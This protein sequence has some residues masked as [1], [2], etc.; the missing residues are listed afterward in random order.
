MSR[1]Y[2]NSPR[3]K[4]SRRNSGGG[5]S[6]VPGIMLGL[7]I[8]LL[9]A[10]GFMLWNKKSPADTPSNRNW[11]TNEEASKAQQAQNDDTPEEI[12][13][14]SSKQPQK[15]K[16]SSYDF[17]EVL[18]DGQP[19]GTREART[20]P[21]V[22][23]PKPPVTA[24]PKP[25]LTPP[26][27]DSTP[28]VEPKPAQQASTEVPK[29]KK[30]EPNTTTEPTTMGTTKPKPNTTSAEPT[31]GAAKPKPNKKYYLQAGSFTNA[32]QADDMK[33]R[34]TMMGLDANVQSNVVGDKVRHK[35]KLGPFNSEEELQRAKAELSL[36]GVETQ[37][38]Q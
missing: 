20:P 9:I 2:R 28:S 14:L 21:A 36:Q 13:A 23:K 4:T 38:G 18:Q 22:S 25:A 15:P 26:V 19:A 33:A 6:M 31:T 16:P 27:T 7:L 5:G 8:G 1:E 11:T 35:V 32:T 30:P 34:L 3:V 29:P 24:E 17:Y 10:G 37:S 12:P